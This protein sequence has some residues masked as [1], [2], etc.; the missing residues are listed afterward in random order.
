M[1]LFIEIERMELGMRDQDEVYV[2][3]RTILWRLRANFTAVLAAYWEPGEGHRR[4]GLK[5]NVLGMSDHGIRGFRPMISA[6]D[7][8]LHVTSH[9]LEPRRD[10]ISLQDTTTVRVKARHQDAQLLV[11]KSLPR[12]L[13]LETP[14]LLQR[15]LLCLARPTILS[16]R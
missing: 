9:A 13:L 10:L 16:I 5:L 14:L 7:A 1:T 2:I 6:L 15:R 11:L 12:L 3:S 8:C 4:G